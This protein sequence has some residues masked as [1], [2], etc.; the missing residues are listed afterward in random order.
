MADGAGAANRRVAVAVA[1][2]ESVD[3]ART[4]ESE[5]F[6]AERVAVAVAADRTG[7]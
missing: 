4:P 1:D 2:W 7:G 6:T 3:G 5:R